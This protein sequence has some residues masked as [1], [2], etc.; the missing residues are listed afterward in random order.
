MKTACPARTDGRL[1]LPGAPLENEIIGVGG[2]QESVLYLSAAA[3]TG[4]YV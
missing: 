2:I 3:H 1:V 4:M